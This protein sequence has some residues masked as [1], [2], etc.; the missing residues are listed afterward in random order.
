MWVFFSVL[1]TFHRSDFAVEQRRG[2]HHS[3]LHERR[4]CGLKRMLCPGTGDPSA[5]S[6]LM[7]LQG[8]IYCWP[9]L[10]GDRDVQAVSLVLL[11]QQ[12][13]TSMQGAYW[14][15]SQCLLYYYLYIRHVPVSLPFFDPAAVKQC[16]RGTQLVIKN[17]LPALLSQ[18]SPFSAKGASSLGEM[19]QLNLLSHLLSGLLVVVLTQHIHCLP[20]TMGIHLHPTLGELAFLSGY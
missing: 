14:S 8:N 18:P 4:F 1:I 20:L 2:V 7:A 12:P 13:S 9:G 15:I 17:L 10:F 19:M 11:Q 5:G 3:A 16:Q 6:E